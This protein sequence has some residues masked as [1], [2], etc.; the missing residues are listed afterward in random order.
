MRVLREAKSL[1]SAIVN[2]HAEHDALV[3]YAL[4]VVGGVLVHVLFGEHEA[5][6]VVDDLHAVQMHE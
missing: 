1:D 2:V 5:L 4:R 3:E 6:L